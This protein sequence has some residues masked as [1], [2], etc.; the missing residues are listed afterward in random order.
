MSILSKLVL[1]YLRLNPRRTSI[2]GISTMLSVCLLTLVSNVF[3]WGFQYMKEAEVQ[4]NGSWHVRYNDISK[5]QAE[6]LKGRKE[7]ARL[8]V[9]KL[10]DTAWQADAELKKVNEDIFSITSQI[11]E[12]AGLA[13]LK[14]KGISDKMPNGDEAVFDIHY[15]MELLSFYGV[16]G[17]S[18]ELPMNYVLFGVLGIIMGISSM[19]IYS[20]FALSFLEKKKYIGLLSCVGASVWQRRMFVFGEGLAAGLPA[21][22]PGIIA[23]CAASAAATGFFNQRLNE[24]YQL[25]IELPHA[26]DTRITVLSA[27]LGVLTIV[28]AVLV[29][30]VQAGKVEPLEL[31]FHAGET[32]PAP[33]DRN[34]YPGCSLE[35][36]LAVRNL[37]YNGKKFLKM[38]ILTTAS[39]LTAFNGYLEIQNMRGAYQLRDTREEKPLDAWVRIYSDNMGLEESL[40]RQI[41]KKEWSKSAVYL[42]VL[43]LGAFTVDKKYVADGLERFELLWW[44]A[45]NPV[46]FFDEKSGQ[47]HYGFPLKIVGVDDM[48]FWEAL[49]QNGLQ[50]GNPEDY[51]VIV[52]D[53]IPVREEGEEDAVYRNVFSDLQNEDITI[54]FGK[55]G[56]YFLSYYT[57]DNGGMMRTGEEE[58]VRLHVCRMAEDRFPLPIVPGAFGLVADDY[59]QMESYYIRCYM[60]H[61]AFR[62]FLEDERIQKTYGRQSGKEFPDLE[63]TKNPVLNYICIERREG[64]KEE[65]IERKLEQIMGEAGLRPYHPGTAP[66]GYFYDTDTWEYGNIE[67]LNRIEMK[68]NAG[69]ILRQIF[70]AGAILLILSFTLFSLASYIATG[71]YVRRREFS[72]LK[73]MGMTDAGLKRMLLY[74]NI[75]LIGASAVFSS[76]MAYYI[77]YCQ[78]REFREGSATVHLNFPYMTLL[79][80]L[81]GMLLLTGSIVLVLV[82]RVKNVNILEALKN[83]NE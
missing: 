72:V 13:T 14:E 48:V 51:P 71:I 62:R 67:I 68:K 49:G 54:R 3:V 37:R 45:K 66:D 75:L 28:S 53:Y 81:L 69:E 24:T 59:T 1:K 34:Y 18:D 8:R 16:T 27:M 19:L 70:M 73:S 38:L 15:H 20:I 82:R 63:R 26:F 23:G 55:Y 40:A 74:E 42:S 21:I 60:P 17:M 39:V 31:I 29:P 52:D 78:L 2:A 22:F 36:N 41:G 83:E 10:S 44:G 33:S 46:V 6:K 61:S 43:D 58:T 30:S 56:D 32:K 80:V 50:M 25:Q 47:K 11:G 57:S 35:F 9:R 12:E 64:A 79:K 65:E 4:L 76:A 77:G 5:E 7:F